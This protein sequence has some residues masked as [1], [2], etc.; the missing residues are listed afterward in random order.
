MTSETD[1]VV[2]NIKHPGIRF[3]NYESA[4]TAKWRATPINISKN[5]KKILFAP[6]IF[7]FINT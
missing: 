1:L 3:R 2:L 4:G 7:M 6:Y 5:L